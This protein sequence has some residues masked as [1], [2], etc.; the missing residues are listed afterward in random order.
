MKKLQI[1]LLLFCLGLFQAI[2][3]P[4]FT[5]EGS[6]LTVLDLRYLIADSVK[7]VQYTFQ[8]GSNLGLSLSLEYGDILPNGDEDFALNAGITTVFL[9][10]F[11]GAFISSGIVAE[12]GFAR[13]LESGSTDFREQGWLL[14]VFFSRAFEFDPLRLDIYLQPQLSVVTR[15]DLVAVSSQIISLPSMQGGIAM[16]FLDSIAVDFFGIFSEN[17]PEFGFGISLFH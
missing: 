3:L 17:A 10:E 5:T 6:S 1:S 16:S 14:A 2:S 11:T 9:N 4:F 12:Y 13:A 8:F 15:E 7:E